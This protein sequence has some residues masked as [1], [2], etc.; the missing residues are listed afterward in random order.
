[1]SS[2]VTFRSS[3]TVNPAAIDASLHL[4]TA[5][6]LLFAQQERYCRIWMSDRVRM[7][8]GGGYPIEEERVIFGQGKPC[9]VLNSKIIPNVDDVTGAY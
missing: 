2:E 8:G 9:L 7:G 1:M 3:R 6:E 5:V 4:G